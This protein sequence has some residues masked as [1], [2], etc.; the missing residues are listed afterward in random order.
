MTELEKLESYFKTENEHWNGFA[1][2]MFCK[3]LQ[4]G[5]FENPEL[6]LQLLDSAI[7]TF[8]MKSE[9]PV[10]AFNEFE[11]EMISQDLTTIQKLF[12][13]EWI[14]KYLR[15]SDFDEIDCSD[16]IDLLW[17]Q[18]ERAKTPK[19]TIEY[20]KP[21]TGNIRNILKELIQNELEQL[22]ETLNNLDPVQRLNI[23]CKL[24]PYVLPKVESVTHRLGEPDEF[25]IRKLHD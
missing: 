15:I 7:K 14:Y 20:N 25:K 19:P 4:E 8:L 18:I 6:P 24:I 10:I 9:T 3:V 13:H 12:L 5:N 2:E 23:L 21:I 16:I 1:F 11:N 22:P 17:S